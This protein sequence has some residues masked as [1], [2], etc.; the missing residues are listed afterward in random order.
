MLSSPTC[1]TI[2][3]VLPIRTERLVIRPFTLDD[4]PR[5]HAALYSDPQAMRFIGGPHTVQRT[6]Q[7][8][9]S[10]I[11]H[12]ERAGYS[13]WAVVEYATGLVIGE[14]GLYPLNGSGPDVELGYALGSRWWGRGYATEA[15]A[16]ILAEA[17]DR[18]AVDRV[19]AVAKAENTASRHV[20][21]KLGFHHEGEMDAWGARHEFFV[22]DAD[23]PPGVA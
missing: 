15:G 3:R 13:F 20:L 5:I 19:V 22:R 10:Y 17:F 1:A 8:I 14:A 23:P 18:L 21:E 9:A 16:G 2:P 6:G 7:G 11:D 12:Q 4:V